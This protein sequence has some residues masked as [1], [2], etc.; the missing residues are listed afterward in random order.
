M[1]LLALFNFKSPEYYPSDKLSVVATVTISSGGPAVSYELRPGDTLTGPG[2]RIKAPDGPRWSG[3]EVKVLFPS[4]AITRME[5]AMVGVP[6]TIY[7]IIRNPDAKWYLDD[8]N[9]AWTVEDVSDPKRRP[10]FRRHMIPMAIPTLRIDCPYMTVTIRAPWMMFLRRIIIPIER[11][12][13]SLR[14]V[15]FVLHRDSQSETKIAM[16]DATVKVMPKSLPSPAKIAAIHR[17]ELHDAPVDWDD[18]EVPDKDAALI[19]QDTPTKL[20]KFGASELE[21]EARQLLSLPI[22]GPLAEHEQRLVDR[23]V[24]LHGLF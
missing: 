16:Q 7:A 3:K 24:Y 1:G 17:V 15:A 12:A 13:D 8:S 20:A 18:W 9:T 4:N 11:E 6:E 14:G 5:P 23:F 2:L 10:P 19:N 21:L 22:N